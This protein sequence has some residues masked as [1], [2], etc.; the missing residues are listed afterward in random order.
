[1][2]TGFTLEGLYSDFFGDQEN[3]YYE[4][5]KAVLD[6]DRTAIKSSLDDYKEN[7]RLDG[8]KM[9]D[10]WFP[11]VNADVFL[12]HS[13]RDERQTVALAGWLSEKCHVRAF[14]DS[15]IW[16]Y[17]D[18][19]LKQIDDVYC[20]NNTAHMYDYGKRNVTTSHV[21]IMLNTAL[22]KMIDKCECLIFV[23]TPNSIVLSEDVKV[24][25]DTQKTLSPWIYSE[26]TFAGM[27]ERKIVKPQSLIHFAHGPVNESTLEIVYPINTERLHELNTTDLEKWAKAISKAHITPSLNILYKSYR[28]EGI[29]EIQKVSWLRG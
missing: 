28:G 14:V 17:S 6:E 23:N 13:H 20:F 10:D 8:K 3:H 24:K 25:D 11:K 2:F 21:H 26:L 16:G 7:G 9:E 19:L 15:A 5:G 1:M 4:I 12:S 29:P 18:D 27:V 22:T